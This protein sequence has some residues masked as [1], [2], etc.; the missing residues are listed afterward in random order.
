MDAVSRSR[1]M[2]DENRAAINRMVLVTRRG[3]RQLSRTYVWS[4]ATDWEQEVDDAD[5]ELLL[6]YRSIGQLLLR[7]DTGAQWKPV[8]AYSHIPVLERHEAR[9]LQDVDSLRR[10]F[11]RTHHHQGVDV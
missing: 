8:V 6:E 1:L 4:K 10:Q 3:E 7:I 5:W 2:T 11:T 9:D